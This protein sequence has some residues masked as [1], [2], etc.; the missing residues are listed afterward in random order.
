[1]RRGETGF[2][3]SYL[4]SES[5]TV[6]F[7]GG[8]VTDPPQSRYAYLEGRGAPL[9]VGNAFMEKHRSGG[10]VSGEMFAGDVKDATALIID[11]LNHF[12]EISEA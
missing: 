3:S 11:N 6:R 2:G 4:S 8:D 1:M 10:V 9:T 5:C 12:P 7:M